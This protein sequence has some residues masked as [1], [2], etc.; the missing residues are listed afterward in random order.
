[1]QALLWTEWHTACPVLQKGGETD[2]NW[3]FQ[4][5]PTNIITRHSINLNFVLADF[6]TIRFKLVIQSR[7]LWINVVHSIYTLSGCIKRQ[8]AST[9]LQFMTKFT[10]RFKAIVTFTAMFRKN[11]LRQSLFIFYLSNVIVDF[12]S[13]LKLTCYLSGTKAVKYIY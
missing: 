10:N 4:P 11:L 2:T 1:M 7:L 3:R 9:L 12:L 6:Q 5:T 13:F 8:S